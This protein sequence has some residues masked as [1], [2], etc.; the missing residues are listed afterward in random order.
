MTT[1][2][3]LFKVLDW[4]GTSNEIKASAVSIG[5]PAWYSDSEYVK[6]VLVE[7]LKRDGSKWLVKF[8]MGVE[9]TIKVKIFEYPDRGR[10]III[11]QGYMYIVSPNENKADFLNPHLPF[12]DLI[13]DSERII[14]SD[15]TSVYVVE[16]NGDVWVSPR[17]SWDG[18]KD[19]VIENNVIKGFAY[20]PIDSRQEWWPFTIHLGTKEITGGTYTKDSDNT[21]MAKWEAKIM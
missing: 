9:G 7:F 13:Y 11:N 8:G 14:T 12:K 1:E 10:V 3:K 15:D 21:G 17:I 16:S 2:G 19:L 20:T 6:G 18:L 5:G 4:D